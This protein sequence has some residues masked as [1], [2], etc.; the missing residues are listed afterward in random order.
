MLHLTGLTDDYVMDGRVISEILG[1]NGNGR[2]QQLAALGACYKQLNASVGSFGS[3][4]LVASTSAL[5]SGSATSDGSYVNTTASLSSLADRRDR[6]ATQIKNELDG[7]EFHGSFP[8]NATVGSQLGSC[9][10]L[11]KQAAALATQT[12]NGP[13]A[14]QPAAAGSPSSRARR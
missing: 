12:G 8:S 9:Q 1:G 7:A 11:L 3:N 6:L 13:A 2:L 5:G 4:T 10:D 14:R